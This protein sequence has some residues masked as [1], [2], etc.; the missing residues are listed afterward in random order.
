M[1]SHEQAGQGGLMGFGVPVVAETLALPLEIEDSHEAQLSTEMR[2]V[3]LNTI[4]VLVQARDEYDGIDVLAK[5][6]REARVLIHTPLVGE[7]SPRDA[8]EH[9][10]AVY[11]IYGDKVPDRRRLSDLVVTEQNGEPRILIAISGHRRL[12]ALQ[13]LGRDRELVKVVF[14]IEPIHALRLQ[15]QENTPKLLKD[16]E[17]AEQ[18]GRLFRFERVWNDRLSV[19]KFAQSVGQKPDVI[20]RD[21]RYFELPD[22]VKKYVVPRG[23]GKNEHGE[24]IIPDQPLMPFNVACQLGR[25]VEAEVVEHDILFLA[26]RFFEEGISSEREASKRVSAYLKEHR[27]NGIDMLSLF[28][29]KAEH[30]GKM[31][32]NHQVASRFERPVDDALAYFE[33]VRI[34]IERGFDDPDENKLSLG[35]AAG[36]LKKFSEVASALTDMMG[37]AFDDERELERVRGEFIR[38]REF[39]QLIEIHTDPNLNGAE[40]PAK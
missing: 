32:R 35:G 6:I 37:E 15:A 24:T 22:G 8:Q 30:E 7:Y 2:I 17:R 20:R 39:S 23:R 19:D 4:N 40:D 3:P 26:R 25:L 10:N 13:E 12:M 5:A 34:A 18:H 9:L 29:F 28:N 14:D 16:Y 31:R 33:R 11:G 38:L 36:R 27:M 1:S 21:L